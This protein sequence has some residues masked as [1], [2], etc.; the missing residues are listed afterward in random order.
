MRYK[1]TRKYFWGEDVCLTLDKV[2]DIYENIYGTS[3]PKYFKIKRVVGNGAGRISIP[4][5]G[6][7][8]ETDL[9]GIEFFA[10]QKGGFALKILKQQQ[11]N[12]F[13]P[14][15]TIEVQAP[16]KLNCSKSHLETLDIKIRNL[17]G[18]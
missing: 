2:R 3:K 1:I 6:L 13:N 14:V 8:K 17:I 4:M 5:Q 10:Y 7:E 12:A 15:Y 18:L 16:G 9:I 11:G